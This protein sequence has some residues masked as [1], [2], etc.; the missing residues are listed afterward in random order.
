MKQIVLLAIVA[1]VCAVGGAT[2]FTAS[3]MPPPQR[4]PGVAQGPIT[5]G[6]VVPT[7]LPPKKPKAADT[8]KK[9]SAKP[10]TAKPT[11]SPVTTDS[12]GTNGAKAPADSGVGK[13][14]APVIDSAT[15]VRGAKSV[16]KVVAS[17]KPKDAV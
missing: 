17:M 4:A 7:T 2:W 16:A 3:L 12:A 1:F 11:P 6:T 5:P 14:P 15:L 8:A 10:A 13:R 9:S